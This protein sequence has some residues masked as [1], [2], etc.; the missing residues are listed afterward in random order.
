M[1]YKIFLSTIIVVFVFSFPLAA[2]GAEV[3]SGIGYTIFTINGVN[4][5]KDGARIN[6]ESLAENLIYATNGEFNNE[7]IFLLLIK[8]KREPLI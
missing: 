8:K 1:N 5:D 4:T 3:C 2:R 7:S 6:R